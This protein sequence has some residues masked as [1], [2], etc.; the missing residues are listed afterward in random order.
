[1]LRPLRPQ[2][3]VDMA[4]NFWSHCTGPGDAFQGNGGA[5]TSMAEI[6][7]VLTRTDV[8]VTTLDGIP[9][10]T[11]DSNSSCRRTPKCKVA[12][13][14]GADAAWIS[15][16]PSVHVCLGSTK[17]TTR[18]SDVLQVPPLWQQRTLPA[19]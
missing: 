16:T 4:V 13:A 9:G 8:A 15:K 10:G 12:E 3:R 11:S 1:M 5:R 2:A 14:K 7:L 18:D 17:A 19:D 6:P